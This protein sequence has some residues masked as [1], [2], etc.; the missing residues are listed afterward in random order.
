MCIRDRF[1]GDFKQ[2]VAASAQRCFEVAAAVEDYPGWH[3]AIGAVRVLERNAAGRP[4]LVE[5]EI[6]AGLTTVKLRLRFAYGPSDVSCERESGDLRSMQ[7]S[8][9]FAELGEGRAEVSYS[10]AMDPGRM[11]SMM[12]SGPVAGRLRVKLVDDVVAGFKRAVE[13]A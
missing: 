12:I 3:A 2:E 10:T 6:D 4:A 13:A 8:F 9:A 1:G 11:L 7:A 5:A